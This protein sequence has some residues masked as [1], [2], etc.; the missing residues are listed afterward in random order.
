MAFSRRC[1]PHILS[2]GLVVAVALGPVGCGGGGDNVEKYTAPKSGDPGRAASVADY[3]ILGAMYPA[4]QPGWYW[5]FKFAGPA[6]QIGAKEADFDKMAQSV[7]LQADP[8]AVPSFDPPA[9]WERTGPRVDS[10]G[11]IQVK[12]DE[13]VKVGGLECTVSYVGGGA[14]GNLSRWAGQVGASPADVPKSTTEFVANGVKATRV[15]LRG[16]KNPAAGRAPMLPA[17]HP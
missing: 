17:G 8:S 16:S 10:R 13:V 2:A 5:Y 11:G 4:G 15:D 9:G 3:R 6:D 12:F 1:F 14:E 7:K